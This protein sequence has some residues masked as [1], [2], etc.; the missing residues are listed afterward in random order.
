MTAMTDFDRLVADWLET[1]GPSDVRVHVVDAA[2]DA[3]RNEGQRRG[4]TATL[5]GSGVW[6]KPDHRS[7]RPSSRALRIA[8]VITLLALTAGSA[9]LVA[10][11]LGPDPFPGAQNG[12]IMVWVAQGRDETGVGGGALHLVA[13]DGTTDVSRTVAAAH[14]FACPHLASEGGRLAYWTADGTLAVEEIGGSG[15]QIVPDPTGPVNVAELLEAWT[16]DSHG[17]AFYQRG[18]PFLRVADVND[19]SV[20]RVSVSKPV[21]GLAWAPN[22]DLGVALDFGTE[23]QITRLAPTGAERPVVRYQWTTATDGHARFSWS[24]DGRYLLYT[25]RGGRDTVSLETA[26]G[27]P[28]TLIRDSD[29]FIDITTAWSPDGQ[30]VAIPDGAGN[31]IVVHPDGT[32]RVAIPLRGPRSVGS[33]RW[34]P[35]G[36]WI[37]A[38]VGDGL[39]TVRP[40]GTGWSAQT[41]TGTRNNGTGRFAWSPDSTRIV[42]QSS[43]W[44]DFPVGI[45]APGGIAPERSMA[46]ERSQ[47]GQ[48]CVEWLPK[49]GG[50]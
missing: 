17:V 42:A 8:I 45:Y 19:R 5:S 49:E 50:G 6:P 38:G 24:S 44:T 30:H 20:R 28:A 4:I 41:I 39:V 43:D 1:A 12:P 29:S 25:S 40:D 9:A 37:A 47:A 26:T 36:S 2:I 3:A 34:S 13:D 23:V 32:D 31:V 48:D 46:F 15:T 7:L 14:S 11:R 35:D 16:A 18:E 33:I 21:V 10:S 22:G 27:R